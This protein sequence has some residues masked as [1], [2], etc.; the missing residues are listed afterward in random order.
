MRTMKLIKGLSLGQ[1]GDVVEVTIHEGMVYIL[2]RGKPH[3]GRQGRPWRY[4]FPVADVA[5]TRMQIHRTIYYR[6]EPTLIDR[7]VGD[8]P[9]PEE[10]AARLVMVAEPGEG[11]GPEIVLQAN[12]VEVKRVHQ[13][14]TAARIKQA[15]PAPAA[16][17]KAKKAAPV[18]PLREVASAG[19]LNFAW[20]PA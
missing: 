12:L 6:G 10:A 2:H 13:A 3:L 20:T 18:R 16:K 19:G 9:V 8:Q 15:T 1:T 17:A 4:A 11:E 5:G 7:M 14:L